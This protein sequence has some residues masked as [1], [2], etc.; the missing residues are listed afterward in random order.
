MRNN[1]K[2]QTQTKPNRFR[3]FGLILFTLVI[4]GFATKAQEQNTSGNKLNTEEIVV[5]HPG[6]KKIFDGVSF[7]GWEADPSTWSI[8]D[9]AIKGVGG[10]SRLCYTKKD[11]GSFR[12]IFTSR[13]DPVNDDH[14]GFM[15]WGDRPTD[16]ARPKVDGAGWLQF[17]PP[18][19]WMWDYH[20]PK[21][22]G[23]K[24]ERIAMGSKDFTQWSTTEVVCNLEKG[25]MS[26][27]VDG[28]ELVRYFHPYPAE[29]TDPEKRIV[30]GPV[31]MMRHGGGTSIY[32]DIY[33]E[34]NPRE[35]K[36][37]TVIELKKE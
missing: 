2:E 35:D 22:H 27:A 3:N 25:T 15:F 14:L 1:L 21:H 30:A 10:S 23:P 32:K 28:V 29:R 20:P 24:L 37:I 18:I 13:M 12:I 6:L 11:Y 33:I 5:A 34:E 16:P 8:V 31:C 26:A 36:L 17:A 4:V 19:G 7:D 9:G